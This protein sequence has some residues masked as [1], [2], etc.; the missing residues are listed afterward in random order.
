MIFVILIGLQV[1]LRFDSQREQETFLFTK[2]CTVALTPNEVYSCS[3][4][5]SFPG[6]K[7]AGV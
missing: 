5:G 1:R 2:S 4:H 7:V 3:T 6:S